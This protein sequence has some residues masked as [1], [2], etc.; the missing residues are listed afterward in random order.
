[1]SALFFAVQLPPQQLSKAVLECEELGPPLALVRERASK[2]GRARESEGARERGRQGRVRQRVLV[3]CLC[4]SPTL[5]SCCPCASHIERAYRQYIKDQLAQGYNVPGQ[6]WGHRTVI[7]TLQTLCQ[8]AL[9]A[10]SM[11]PCK[12]QATLCNDVTLVSC[13]AL[14]R[15]PSAAAFPMLHAALP[16][17]HERF[18]IVLKSALTLDAAS[19]LARRADIEHR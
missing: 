7:T 9:S 17:A 16:R 15:L 2:M 10:P 6:V 14:A 3:P 5:P 1:M 19:W 11:L 8:P 13:A 12:P 4:A 18:T